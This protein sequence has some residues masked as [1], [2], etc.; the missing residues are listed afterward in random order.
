MVEKWRGINLNLTGFSIEHDTWLVG[1]KTFD[2]RTFE[3]SL[4][5]KKELIQI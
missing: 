4:K 1:D 2:N 3:Y 5:V